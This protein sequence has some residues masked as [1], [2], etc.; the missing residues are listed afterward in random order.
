MAEK[1]NE[2]AGKI[3]KGL[4]KGLGLGAGA[5][6]AMGGIVYGA[7]NSFFTGNWQ[8]LIFC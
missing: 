4:P 1:M 5:L 6:M 8:D 3:P 7:A 2:F